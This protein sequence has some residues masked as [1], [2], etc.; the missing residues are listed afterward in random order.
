MPKKMIYSLLIYVKVIYKILYYNI[1][2]I[3]QEKRNYTPFDNLI[4]ID[5]SCHK[6]IC[7]NS[8]I[9]FILSGLSSIYTFI[10]LLKIKSRILLLLVITH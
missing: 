8:Q 9:T 3:Y 10:G 1:L 7:E 4:H 2:D 5:N 6:V